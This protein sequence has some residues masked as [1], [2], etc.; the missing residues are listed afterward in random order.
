MEQDEQEKP[1]GYRDRKEARRRLL[2]EDSY[3]RRVDGGGVSRWVVW[4]PKINDYVPGSFAISKEAAIR[5][6]MQ[7]QFWTRSF[8][9]Q[10]SWQRLELFGFRCVKVKITEI[11]R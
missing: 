4:S 8:E 3:R 9:K 7:L 1:S 5:Q 6:L 2:K 11:D 10:R